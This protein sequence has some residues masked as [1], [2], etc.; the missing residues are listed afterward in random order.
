M[1]MN[2]AGMSAVAIVASSIMGDF[3][4]CTS[5]NFQFSVLSCIFKVSFSKN[6]WKDMFQS[7]IGFLWLLEL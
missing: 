3:Y 4:I 6:N 2:L 7:Y 1:A 5:L